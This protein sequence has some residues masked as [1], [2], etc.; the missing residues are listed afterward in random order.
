MATKKQVAT[1]VVASI[2]NEEDNIIK[3][4]LKTT[5]TERRPGWYNNLR[6]NWTKLK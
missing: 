3:K 1:I 6:P 5:W 4:A 2:C